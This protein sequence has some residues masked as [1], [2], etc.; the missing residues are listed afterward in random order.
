MGYAVAYHEGLYLQLTWSMNLLNHGYYGWKDESINYLTLSDGQIVAMP[1][2]INAATSAVQYLFS[3]LY[4][5]GRWQEAVSSK[6]LAARYA[7]LFG[8]PFDYTYEPLI[9]AD[10]AQP[11][12]QLPFEDGVTWS[13]TSGPHG[14]WA[15]G[16]A[17]AALDFAPPSESLGCTISRE[18]VVAIADGYIVRT[19]TG[20]VIQELDGDGVEQ[21]GWTILYMHISSQDRVQPGGFVKAGD[22]IGHPSCEGGYST[23]TH[24]HIARR[25]NGEWIAADSSIPFVMDGWIPH[26]SYYEYDGSLTKSGVTVIAW[27]GKIDANQISR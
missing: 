6:G 14:G 20:A 3:R 4:S 15:D 26:S 16:S 18:W 9:P 24:L 7:A 23:G 8:N 12:F 11:E 22:P 21:T 10:L 25:Y 27:N 13:M 2:T 17:W 19:G 5:L 1:G